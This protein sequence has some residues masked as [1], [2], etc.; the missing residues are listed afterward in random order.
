VIEF[1]PTGSVEVL[2]VAIP[3]LIVPVPS[4][5]PPFQALTDEPPHTDHADAP[6]PPLPVT[7]LLESWPDAD[8]N[9]DTDPTSAPCP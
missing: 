8:G 5:V 7:A 6:F 4:V 2:Y 1:E 3:P 9:L